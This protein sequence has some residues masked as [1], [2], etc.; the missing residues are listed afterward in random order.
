MLLRAKDLAKELSISVRTVYN[1][2]NAG[3]LP[4]G[5]KIGRS[6]RWDSDKIK[7]WLDSLDSNKEA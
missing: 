1:Y 4:A 2:M 6:R 5:V 7:N 3:Q